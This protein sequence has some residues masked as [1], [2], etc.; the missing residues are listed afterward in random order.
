MNASFLAYCI[1]Y[2]AYARPSKDS[3]FL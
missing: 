3:P 2:Y 1:F